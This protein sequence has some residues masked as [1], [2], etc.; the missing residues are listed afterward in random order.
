MILGR[1]H[2][3]FDVVNCDQ[4]LKYIKVEPLKH[5]QDLTK[6]VQ[7]FGYFR[8]KILHHSNVWMILDP[9]CILEVLPS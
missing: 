6:V 7:I 3:S 9:D 8:S 1:V 4:I 5:D 2:V